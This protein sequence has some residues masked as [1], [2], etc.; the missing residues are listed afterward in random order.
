MALILE[1]TVEEMTRGDDARSS[2]HDSKSGFVCVNNNNN[3]VIKPTTP[4]PVEDPCVNCFKEFPDT[5][6]L[7][8]D[9]KGLSPN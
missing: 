9:I 3:K 2:G 5:T 7:L 8:K 4:T 1:T 6:E